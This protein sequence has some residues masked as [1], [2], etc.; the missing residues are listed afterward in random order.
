MNLNWGFLNFQLGNP[1]VEKINIT[2]PGRKSHQ[3]PVGS[4]IFSDPT[5]DPG[6][7]QGW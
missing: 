7:K 4:C 5:Q 6:R 2:H 1:F 3:D